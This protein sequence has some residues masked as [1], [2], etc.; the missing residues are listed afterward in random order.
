MAV[1]VQCTRKADNSP[2][3]LNLDN[4]IWL[5]WNE[6]ERFTA[7]SWTNGLMEAI[8]RVTETP[9]EI[10]SSADPLRDL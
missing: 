2:I 6:E 8:V 10:L 5:R 3:Y 1:W 4:A 7:V 9:D